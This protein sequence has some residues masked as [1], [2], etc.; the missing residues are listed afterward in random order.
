MRLI[1]FTEIHTGRDVLINPNHVIAVSTD[2]NGDQLI[3]LS[4]ESLW[5]VIADSVYEI[6]EK[7]ELGLNS[8]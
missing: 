8:P 5:A 4:N 2:H 7:L 3:H 1:R 6:A